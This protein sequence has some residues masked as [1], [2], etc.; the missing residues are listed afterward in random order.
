MGGRTA[1]GGRGRRQ[2]AEP[3]IT[4]EDILRRIRQGEGRSAS[5]HTILADFESTPLARRQI[6]DILTALVKEGRLDR[7][8]GSRYEARRRSLIDGTIL[9]HR[10]GYGFVIPAQKIQGVES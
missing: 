5:L 10:E 2:P 7:H 3:N 9:L 6:K 8:K 4:K 1:R